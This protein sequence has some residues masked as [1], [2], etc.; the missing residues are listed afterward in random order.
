MIAEVSHC[1]SSFQLFHVHAQQ[2]VSVLREIQQNYVRFK[3][4]NPH[5]YW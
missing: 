5:I 2:D 4:K 3:S 1:W